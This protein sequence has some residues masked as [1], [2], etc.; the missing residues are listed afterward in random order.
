MAEVDQVLFY[1]VEAR[2]QAL[3]FD[4]IEVDIRQRAFPGD[5]VAVEVSC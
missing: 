2:G 5:G 4:A 3:E 1:G